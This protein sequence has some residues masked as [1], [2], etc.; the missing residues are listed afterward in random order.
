MR[1]KYTVNNKTSTT[2]FTITSH[3][4]IKA[5]AGKQLTLFLEHLNLHVFYC[6]IFGVV[7]SVVVSAVVILIAETARIKHVLS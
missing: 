7:D 5:K 6:R 1:N 3:S 4:M 2:V